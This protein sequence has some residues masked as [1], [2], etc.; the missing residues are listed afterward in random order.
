MAIALSKKNIDVTLTYN[1]NKTAADEVVAT[2][3]A[4]GQK[5]VALPFDVCDIKSYPDFL[6]QVLNTLQ[7]NWNTNQFDF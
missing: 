3:N 1:A 2:I 6:N 5:A 7:E 4:N